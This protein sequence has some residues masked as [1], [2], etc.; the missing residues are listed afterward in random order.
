MSCTVY[1]LSLHHAQRNTSWHS[2]DNLARSLIILSAVEHEMLIQLSHV[3]L[4][5][6]CEK[7]VV[8]GNGCSFATLLP[9]IHHRKHFAIDLKKNTTHQ[10]YDVTGYKKDEKFLIPYSM[11]NKKKLPTKISCSNWREI[12]QYRWLNG[13]KPHMECVIWNSC[14]IQIRRHGLR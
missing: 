14:I 12:W 7:Y 6:A 2:Q 8:L 11:L 5:T 9:S 1:L 10:Q 13:N 4:V 3:Q